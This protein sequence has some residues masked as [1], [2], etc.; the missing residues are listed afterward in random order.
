MDNIKLHSLLDKVLIKISGEYLAGKQGF[1][2]DP[3]ILSN[4]AH[5]IG[6]ISKD[7]N[8]QIS[9]VIGGGNFFRGVSIAAKG[10]D[11]VAADYMGMMSTIMNS[12]ALQSEL[13]KQNIDSRV[14][15]ALTIRK[16]AEPYIRRR[17][18]RHLEKNRVVILSGGTGNPYFT[19][20]TSAV[21]RAVEVGSKLVLKAT[22]VDGVYNEDPVNNPNAKKY[23]SLTF[24]EV[25]DKEL[26]V[27]DLTAMTLC[28]ENNLP[29]IVFDIG[30][31]GSL[32]NIFDSTKEGS[33]I[34]DKEIVW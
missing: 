29:V 10:M 5:N 7:K 19:T 32:I 27:M 6:L 21:L 25:I 3:S 30:K 20:D 18:S 31:E 14:M 28:K 8:R 16:V 34:S 1:G 15:S 9:I 22:K 33:I 26:R 13:E 2:I 23:D 11:R 12:L 17:A 4:L 24:K